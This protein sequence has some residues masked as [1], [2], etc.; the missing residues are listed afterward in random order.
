MKK[1]Q[2]TYSQSNQRIYQLKHLHANLWLFKILSLVRVNNVR[3]EK[4]LRVLL[5]FIHNT[6]PWIVLPGLFT[7]TTRHTVNLV[8]PANHTVLHSIV[9]KVVNAES[10]KLTLKISF[11]YVYTQVHKG[12]NKINSYLNDGARNVCR[13]KGK[14]STCHY[15]STMWGQCYGTG[16]GTSH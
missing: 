12:E 8:L 10:F 3:K 4:I 14:E 5:N 1:S 7:L 11:Y 13:R 15:F 16:S 2:I 9:T 6:G